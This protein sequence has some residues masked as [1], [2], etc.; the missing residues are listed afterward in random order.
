MHHTIIIEGKDLQNAKAGLE[1]AE[2]RVAVDGFAELIVAGES[3]LSYAPA[4]MPVERILTCEVHVRLS[5][6]FKFQQLPVRD[7]CLWNV[8]QK[9]TISSK[10]SAKAVSEK[11]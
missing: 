6:G 4:R 11:S 1:G 5:G 10:V 3:L 8:E 9:N 2:E 7:L